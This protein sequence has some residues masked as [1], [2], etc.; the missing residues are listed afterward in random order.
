M[1]VFVLDIDNLYILLRINFDPT[2]NGRVITMTGYIRLLYRGKTVFE[3]PITA[4]SEPL[5]KDH[6][7]LPT[8][9]MELN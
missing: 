4:Y 2:P 7:D 9:W 1:P 8:D 5:N 6:Q 3:V